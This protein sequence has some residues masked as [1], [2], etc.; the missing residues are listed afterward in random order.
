[1]VPNV[2]NKTESIALPPSIVRGRLRWKPLKSDLHTI[3]QTAWGVA[4]ESPLESDRGVTREENA[5]SGSRHPLTITLVLEGPPVK[6]IHGLA[7]LCRIL[8]RLI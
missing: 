6:L 3:V 7:P 5:R 8:A 4:S 1:M 2:G